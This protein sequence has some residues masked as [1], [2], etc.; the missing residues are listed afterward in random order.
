MKFHGKY[1]F[2]S[3][4]FIALVAVSVIFYPFKTPDRQDST[5]IIDNEE[6][7]PESINHLLTN[8]NSDIPETAKLDRKIEQFLKTWR[9]KGASIAI[10]KDEK[11]IYAQG[12]DWP[13]RNRE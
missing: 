4:F 6:I 8:N 1:I 10:L 2:P 9:I 3:L 7:F 11:L 5:E 13:M 12:K